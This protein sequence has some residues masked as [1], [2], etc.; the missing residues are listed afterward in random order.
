M[1]DGSRMKISPLF[2]ILWGVFGLV[3]EAIALFNNVPND[4]L[5]GTITTHIPGWVI[6]SFIG[7]LLWHF[8][9]SK[10]KGNNR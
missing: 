1:K 6:F 8:M 10:L 4:T 5:T 3:L 9:V 7:W 2:W